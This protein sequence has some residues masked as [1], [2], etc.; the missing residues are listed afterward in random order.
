MRYVGGQHDPVAADEIEAVTVHIEHRR[1][2]YDDDPLVVALVEVDR[3]GQRATQ[4]VLDDDIADARHF[5]GVLARRRSLARRTEPA[6]H[7]ITRTV[8]IPGVVG[9]KMKSTHH[10]RG[11]TLYDSHSDLEG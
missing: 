2:G 6:P 8:T 4:D 10:G 3:F 1:A 5:L 9:Q 11:C 7:H